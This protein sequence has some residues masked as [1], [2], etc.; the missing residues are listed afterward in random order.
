[1]LYWHDE[2][3]IVHNYATSA[4]APATPVVVDLL[5]FCAEWRTIDEIARALEATS[6]AMRPLVAALRSKTFLQQK[7]DVVDPRERAMARFDRWNPAAGFFHTATKRV[8][9][10]PQAVANRLLRQQ[11]RHWPMPSPIKRIAGTR[12]IPLPRPAA[13]ASFAR[14]LLERRTWRRF[15]PAAIDRDHLSTLLALSAG[16]QKWVAT[17]HGDLPL[18]TAPSGGARHPIECYVAVRRVAGIRPGL[19]HYAAGAHAL[20]R[21]H[22]GDPTPR[23]R[24][25]MP[26]SRYFARAAFVIAFTAVF[27][28]QLWRYPYARA[29]RAALIEAGHVCQTFCLTATALGL[30][31][32]CLMGLADEEIERDLRIDGITEAALYAAGAGRRPRGLLPE[33]ALL[34]RGVLPAR[35]NSRISPK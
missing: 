17:E 28:R 35:P 1:V 18:K 4:I 12:R 21:I 26:Q 22:G 3:M 31:P 7:D 20:E 27:E 23:L 10:L 24:A 25:W 30:A 33:G 11:A 2:R 5:D 6:A 13:P 16:V 15:S 14:V 32:F 29:Y 19:Y 8:R 34:P 9:F